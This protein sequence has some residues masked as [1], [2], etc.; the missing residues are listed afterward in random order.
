MGNLAFQGNFV[1]VSGHVKGSSQRGPGEP[2]GRGPREERR[3]PGPSYLWLIAGGGAEPG[4]KSRLWSTVH[5]TACWMSDRYRCCQLFC[6]LA[7]LSTG[8]QQPAT[9]EFTPAR[10]SAPDPTR[11]LAD[12]LTGVRCPARAPN[13]G[14]RTAASWGRSQPA[15]LA[16]SSS[17]GRPDGSDSTGLS[18]S[19]SISSSRS[20]SAETP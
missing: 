1:Y 5:A 14:G 13:N 10:Q 2:P 9:R 11:Q 4:V 8:T 7:T 12:A 20:S 15:P 17:R 18:S 19:Y 3:G 16:S 6:M